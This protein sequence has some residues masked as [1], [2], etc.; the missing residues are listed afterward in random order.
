[1]AEAEG[2]ISE[3]NYRG[4]E[5]SEL[6]RDGSEGSGRRSATQPDDIEPVTRRVAQSHATGE[7]FDVRVRLM[8]N[9]QYR[10]MRAQ[11]YPRR[12]EEGRII[13]WY[14]YTEDIHESVLIE[15]QMRWRS[16]ERRV[17]KEWVST[18]RSRWSPYH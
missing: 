12:D 10:W 1:M 5:R 18:C 14:G 15:E 6:E 7:P 9:D 16:E 2:R 4:L 17:G 13:R 11:A 8:V 3:D